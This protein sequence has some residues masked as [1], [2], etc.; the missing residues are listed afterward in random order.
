MLF[1]FKR[2]RCKIASLDNR[3][4]EFYVAFSLDNLIKINIFHK[5]KNML[6]RVDKQKTSIIEPLKIDTEI[7]G[8]NIFENPDLECKGAIIFDKDI[9]DYSFLII[10]NFKDIAI[11]GSV[12]PTASFDINGKS[13]TLRFNKKPPANILKRLIDNGCVSNIYIQGKLYHH[14]NDLVLNA[15]SYMNIPAGAGANVNLGNVT[16]VGKR[17]DLSDPEEALY[18][19]DKDTTL[20]ACSNM[21]IP[22]GT[23]VNLGNVTM[24]GK[25]LDFSNSQPSSTSTKLN[26]FFSNFNINPT[27]S[28]TSHLDAEENIKKMTMHGN[29]S[30]PINFSYKNR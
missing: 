7:S 9:K 6:G 3:S 14:N 20:N 15:H 16:I 2:I 29:E 23:S 11:N 10:T 8:Y 12:D 1:A 17:I 4:L 5:V 25:R 30:N 13:V 27:T 24:I 28:K 18:D 26:N 19:Q 22:A 21:T